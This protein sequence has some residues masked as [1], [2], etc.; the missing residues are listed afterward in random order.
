MAGASPLRIHYHRD[1]D[2]MCSAAILAHV[3]QHKDGD[4]VAVTSVNY[5][6]RR[7][8]E[9]FGEGTLSLIHI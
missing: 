4:E 3:L 1:F 5:D 6:Q 8:W 7:D 2:G 9:R